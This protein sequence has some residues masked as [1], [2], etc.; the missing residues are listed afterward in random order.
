MNL[1]ST[2]KDESNVNM[3]KQEGGLSQVNT[4]YQSG[5]FKSLIYPVSSI[6]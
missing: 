5:F 1:I 3:E 6:P 4:G 2:I